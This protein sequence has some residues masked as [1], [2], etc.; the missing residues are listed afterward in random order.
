V[1][2]ASLVLTLSR[3]LSKHATP[4]ITRIEPDKLS[5]FRNKLVMAA[6]TDGTCAAEDERLMST[7]VERLKGTGKSKAN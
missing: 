7:Y 3:S 4:K 1:F 5:L 6:T 2:D